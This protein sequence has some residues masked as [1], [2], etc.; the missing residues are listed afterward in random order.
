M[1]RNGP[2]RGISD[3]F[4][5]TPPVSPSCS[6]GMSKGVPFLPPVVAAWEHAGSKLATGEGVDPEAFLDAVEKLAPIADSLGRVYS[7]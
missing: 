3:E 4:G 7:V 5:T 2:H 6:C 1:V